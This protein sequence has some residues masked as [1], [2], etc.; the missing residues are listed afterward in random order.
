MSLHRLSWARSVL[1]TTFFACAL[2]LISRS[3]EAVPSFA[4]QTGF[5]C[6][7][8]HVAFPELTAFGR[9]FKAGG[10]T[11]TTTKQVNDKQG[12]RSD[13]ALLGLPP[14]GVMLET[15]YTHTNQNQPASEPGHA[16]AKNDD[17]NFPQQFSLFYAGKIA[18]MVGAFVQVTYDG[19]ADHFSMDNT[20][21]RFA[22]TATIRGTSLAWGIS[23]NNNPSLTDLWHGTPAWGLPFSSSEVAPG[24]AA[25]SLIDGALAQTVAGLSIYGYWNNMVYAEIAAYHSAPIGVPR[26]LDGTT[27]ATQAINGL[28]PYW[29]LALSRDFGAHSVE[30]GTYGL[31]ANIYPGGTATTASGTQPID[32][33]GPTNHFTDA[34]IDAQYQYVSQQHSAT[35]VGAWIHEVQRLDA[36]V[37]LG[38][39][40]FDVHTLDEVRLSGSYLFDRLLGA[41]L[42]WFY[43]NGTA[44]SVLYAPAPLNGSASG[45]PRSNAIQAEVNVTPWLNTRLAL[46]YTAYL[47]FN[48]GTNNYDGS[49]RSASANNTLYALAWLVF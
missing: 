9:A 6:S 44:D 34:A 28:A 29:R 17:V 35:F 12:D 13:L 5:S 8:C 49:G 2:V 7:Q 42:S 31:E 40:G 11:M 1:C 26:P 10:Y 41:R 45:S 32:L 33:S 48:G 16:T 15:S 43:V 4:R 22:D 23:L 36:G 38:Q 25:A 46:Q 3:A 30:I 14:L 37:A 27:G 19:V 47:A 20:D 21:I 18:P 39:S 24:P